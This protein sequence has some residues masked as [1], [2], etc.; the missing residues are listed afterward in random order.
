MGYG[1]VPYYIFV[2]GLNVCLTCSVT[3]PILGRFVACCISIGLLIVGWISI[4]LLMILSFLLLFFYKI[5]LISNSSSR[6]CFCCYLIYLIYFLSSITI[7]LALADAST[8]LFFFAISL[9]LGYLSLILEGFLSLSTPSSWTKGSTDSNDFSLLSIICACSILLSSYITLTISI[10]FLDWLGSYLGWNCLVRWLLPSYYCTS[11]TI[12]SCYI[13]LFYKPFSSK[14]WISYRLIA[15]H[16]DTLIYLSINVGFNLLPTS[17][18]DSSIYSYDLYGSY[19]ALKFAFIEASTLCTAFT[20]FFC[21]VLSLAGCFSTQ[22][23]LATVFFLGCTL[24][25]NKSTRSLGDISFLWSKGSYALSYSY[26]SKMFLPLTRGL[27]DALG[28][29]LSTQALLTFWGCWLRNMLWLTIISSCY[30]PKLEWDSLIS[31][32]LSRLFIPINLLVSIL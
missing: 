9:I 12:Y 27:L 32:N 24:L 8:L 11:F 26:A 7:L 6:G 10:L 22:N 21:N 17:I 20:E 16:S 2:L 25:W 31:T 19:Y 29:V 30:S 1:W 18:G 13:L 4:G 23:V 14:Y 5:S 15:L 28:D 3:N